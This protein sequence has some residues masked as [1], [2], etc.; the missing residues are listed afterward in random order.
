M[1]GIPTKSVTMFAW[2]C[3]SALGALSGVMIAPSTTVSLS[4]MDIVFSN[5][6]LA[7]FF[8]GYQTFHGPVI[9]AFIIGIAKNLIV[10]YWSS[11]WGELMIYIVVFVFI[12]FRPN[13]LIGKASVKKV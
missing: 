1:L 11:V 12:V 10:Y 6:F 9:A 2:A 4:V 8:G 13:G 3:A 5:A 7:C